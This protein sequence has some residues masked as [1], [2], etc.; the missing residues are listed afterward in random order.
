MLTNK[1]KKMNII[2]KKTHAIILLIFVLSNGLYANDNTIIDSMPQNKISKFKNNS[3]DKEYSAEY[4]M[5]L[6]SKFQILDLNNEKLKLVIEQKQLKDLATDLNN[7]R[8]LGKY[9]QFDFDTQNNKYPLG[10]VNRIIND[11]NVYS[12]KFENGKGGLGH[13]IV[14]NNLEMS[15]FKSDLEEISGVD[16]KFLEIK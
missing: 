11:V 2:Y 3:E 14:S 1:T 7:K 4:K 9:L 12:F 8:L 10:V 6:N 5:Y 16:F 13:I 15:K